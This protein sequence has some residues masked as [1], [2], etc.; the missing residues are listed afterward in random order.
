MA[1]AITKA[2]NISLTMLMRSFHQWRDVGVHA[3][4]RGSEVPASVQ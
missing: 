1:P 4:G 3:A 2:C